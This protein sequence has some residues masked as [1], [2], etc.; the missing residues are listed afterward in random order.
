MTT[1]T[2]FEE[3]ARRSHDTASLAELLAQELVGRFVDPRDSHSPDLAAV[4]DLLAR[5]VRSQ[6]DQL[7][8][9]V[10]HDAVIAEREAAAGD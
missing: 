2:Q 9:M 8:A 10:D 1:A 5:Q 3:V 6:A 7:M 4:A